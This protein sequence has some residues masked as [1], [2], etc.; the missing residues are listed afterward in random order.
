MIAVKPAAPHNCK[1]TMPSQSSLII[2]CDPPP[3][4]PHHEGASNATQPV[5]NNPGSYINTQQ[6]NNKKEQSTQEKIQPSSVF[7]LQVFLF[8][9]SIAADFSQT[10]AI[11]SN[12][13]QYPTNDNNWQKTLRNLSAIHDNYNLTKSLYS[14]QNVDNSSGNSSSNMSSK[15]GDESSSNY[16]ATFNAFN[17]TSSVSNYSYLLGKNN[18]SYNSNRIIAPS[19]AC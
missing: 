15:A 7:F 16:S 6:Q 11:D 2:R 12:S 10:R 1:A 13:N 8:N 17:A 9:D 4:H 18:C 14:I 3:H 19:S 5:E